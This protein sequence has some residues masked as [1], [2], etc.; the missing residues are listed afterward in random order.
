MG[1][2]LLDDLPVPVPYHPGPRVVCITTYYKVLHR[3]V[4][5]WL[6]LLYDLPVPV[7]YHPGPRLGLSLP[8]EQSL[9][10]TH[11]AHVR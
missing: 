9:L 7:P 4:S 3:R 5:M 6:L 2:L 8:G 1:L 11:H 10:V